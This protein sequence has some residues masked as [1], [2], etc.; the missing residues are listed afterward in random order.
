[1]YTCR[2]AECPAPAVGR[3]SSGPYRDASFAVVQAPSDLSRGAFWPW[4]SPEQKAPS[5]GCKVTVWQ[6]GER[7]KSATSVTRTPW[8]PAAP[9][10][11][12]TC[13][14]RPQRSAP[15]R[16]GRASA[17]RVA[18]P[19]CRDHRAAPRSSR[20]PESTCRNTASTVQSD[21][22]FNRHSVQS[23][24]PSAGGPTSNPIGC[25]SFTLRAIRSSPRP[26]ETSGGQLEECMAGPGR[27]RGALQKAATRPDLPRTG[28][29]SRRCTAHACP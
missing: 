9:S 2:S 28:R 6:C 15:A 27:A 8:A 12:G 22:P 18:R 7:E 25:R 24:A 4:A 3:K 5:P 17:W 21:A 19:S 10:G 16:H 13:G 26:E 1:M 23:D 29:P 14:S 20:V 11:P